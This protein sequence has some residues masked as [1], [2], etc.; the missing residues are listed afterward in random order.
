MME[1]STLV[2]NAISY[3]SKVDNM[4]VNY[5]ENVE[6]IKSYEDKLSSLSDTYKNLEVGYAYLEKLINDE[7]EKFIREVESLLT[8]ALQ[9]IFTDKNYECYIKTDKESTASIHIKYHDEDGNLICPNIR[10]GVGGGIRTIVGF[11]LQVFFILQYDAERIVFVDE[12]FYAISEE[13]LPNFLDFV[14]QL[15]ES[16]EFKILLITHDRDR[17][18]PF[19]DKVYR[20]DDGRSVL[21]KGGGQ[22]VGD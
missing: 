12:G 15:I 18:L 21:I 5:E 13:Y 11:L 7:S 19:A 20:I 3:K 2:N 22:E 16:K 6:K 17:I 9:A 4:K 1:V 8:V 14:Q 10:K